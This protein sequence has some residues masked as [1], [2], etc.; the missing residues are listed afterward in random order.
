MILKNFIKTIYN[1]NAVLKLCLGLC[2]TIAVTTSIQ[3]GIGISIATTF[4]LLL[5]SFFIS[6]LKVFIHNKVRFFVYLFTSAFWTSITDIFIK[7]YFLDVHKSLGIFIP[8]ITVNGILLLHFEKV[9]IKK[10]PFIST[11]YALG[12]GIG[13]SMVVILIS[14]IR[15]II[16]S[17]IIT[18][19]NFNPVLTVSIGFII[20]GII[21]GVFRIFMLNGEEK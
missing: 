8:L 17:Q 18:G 9:S 16:S 1:D 19:I 12:T 14:S 7:A 5:S 10:N 20:L 2:P 13:F 6:L 4:V 11:I 21:I 3:N 15:Q